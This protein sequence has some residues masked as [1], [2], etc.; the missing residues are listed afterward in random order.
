MNRKRAASIA[1][2]RQV[3][4]T[5]AL[6]Q[7]SLAIEK[8]RQASENL[9]VYRKM[10]SEATLDVVDQNR[11]GMEMR[12]LGDETQAWREGI[13]RLESVFGSCLQQTNIAHNQWQQRKVASEGSSRLLDRAIKHETAVEALETA[14]ATDDLINS[15]HN[16]S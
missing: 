14:N 9:S 1:R 4:E 2:I 12:R 7:W 10:A 5:L 13:E 11:S 15:R 6:A 16:R 8:Q 3:Q